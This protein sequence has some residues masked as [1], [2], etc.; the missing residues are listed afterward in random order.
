MTLVDLATQLYDAA[1]VGNT[2]LFL[3]ILKL[4]L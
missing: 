4:S 1:K 2:K 3:I